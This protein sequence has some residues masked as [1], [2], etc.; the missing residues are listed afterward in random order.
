[1]TGAYINQRHYTC[2][3]L[4]EMW[5][6]SQ[7]TLFRLFSREA[8]VLRVGERSTHRRT[9]VSLRIPSCVAERVYA[10]MTRPS[11]NASPP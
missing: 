8:D 4:A 5:G 11:T 7:S 2:K 6:L 1:M 10:R 3:E 9:R